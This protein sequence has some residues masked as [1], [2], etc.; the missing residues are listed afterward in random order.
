MQAPE[1]FLHDAREHS[2]TLTGAWARALLA[3]TMPRAPVVANAVLIVLHGDGLAD[4]VHGRT[5]PCSA[6]GVF[7]GSDTCKLQ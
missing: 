1:T 4:V 7:S 3:F 5:T 6:I 2:L